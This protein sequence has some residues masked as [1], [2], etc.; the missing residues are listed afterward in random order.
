MWLVISGD[1][2]KGVGGGGDV[3]KGVGS[4]GDVAVGV[5]ENAHAWPM[6]ALARENGGGAGMLDGGGGWKRYDGPMFG[7]RWL[8]NIEIINNQYLKF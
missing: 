1:V 3:V 6:W 2:A 4:G 8:P 5:D 7:N